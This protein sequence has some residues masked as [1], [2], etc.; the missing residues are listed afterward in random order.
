MAKPIKETP[1]LKGKDAKV[2]LNNIKEN[3]LVV[4]SKEEISK[5]KENFSKLSAIA[6]F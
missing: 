4:H 2:F 1:V 5:I 3:K 6:Q